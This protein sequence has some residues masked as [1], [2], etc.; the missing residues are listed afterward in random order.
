MALIWMTENDHKLQERAGTFEERMV[1]AFKKKDQKTIDNL[2]KEA[3]IIRDAGFFSPWEYRTL[4]D[5][6]LWEEILG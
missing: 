6:D 2:L 5:M 3:K 1:D 4:T